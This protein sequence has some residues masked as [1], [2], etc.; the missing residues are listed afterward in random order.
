MNRQSIWRTIVFFFL[1][2]LGG[3]Y[4]LPNWFGDDPAIQVSPKA[5]TAVN[6]SLKQTI[7]SALD[8]HHIAYRSIQSDGRGYLIR[9]LH[10]DDQ[11]KAQDFIQASIGS[12]YSVALNLAPR[13]PAWLQAIGAQPMKL[14]LDLRGG[15][16]FLF[17]VDTKTMVEAHVKSDMHALASTLR[18]QLIRYASISMVGNDG[19]QVTFTQSQ[20]HDK[21]L[22]TIESDFT[23]YQAKTTQAAG[24]FTI[25]LMMLPQA[26]NDLVRYAVRQNITILNKRVNALGVSEPVIAPQ[27]ADQISID[28]PGV[29]DS[30]RAK[31]Q[32]GAVATVQM[33]MVDTEHDPFRAAETGMVPFG[34]TLFH[35]EGRPYLLKNTVVL[36]GSS[37]TSARTGVDQNGRP[38]VN[39]TVG[40]GGVGLF[41]KITGENVGKPMATV[42]VQTVTDKKL[43]HG[44][45]ELV[46]RQVTKIINVATIQSAL[47]RSFQIMGLES[48]DYAKDLAL[49]LQSGAYV[50]P[51]VPIAEQVVGP[52]M[53]QQNIDMG[54]RACLLGSLLV[55]IFMLVYYRPFGLVADF[56]LILNVI[57]VVAIQ[58]AL[59]FT[60]TL[61][62]IAALVLTVGM[63]VD[64][65]VLINERIRE[66]LRIGM[67]PQAAISAGYDRAFV[68]IV[69]ANVTT[70]IVAAILFM[71]GT[72]PVQGFA[73][74]L[75]IGLLTSMV[76]AIFFTRAFV[77][78]IYGGRRQVK[79][80]SIGIRVQAAGDAKTGRG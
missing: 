20:A 21:A 67:S 30:A 72:G 36:S 51:I 33:Q 55:F 44:K 48:I 17:Q 2:L 54:V 69:D 64:A 4:A 24:R 40:G 10:A 59:G 37:I 63:A 38:A 22:A 76:T 46:P 60:M 53:G 75:T 66:E 27:G 7:V 18:D 19:F 70:L 42:Y 25:T 15:I 31:Q 14:G 78:L 61:P 45:V 6:A 39:L 73:V 13:T 58:S 71:F 79:Q 8:E 28:L 57:F 52:S 1:I 56:A 74:T 77:N 43:V 12:G 29:Q 3:I 9:L 80:L 41:N 49:Q 62:G 50:A 23:Q 47:G 34:S 5:T 68:T 65:N 35:Y 11:A 16:H 32:I 26:V